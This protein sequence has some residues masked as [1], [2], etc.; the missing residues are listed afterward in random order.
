M[1]ESKLLL[2]YLCTLISDKLNQNL[3]S[4]DWSK[5][6]GR[7]TCKKNYISHALK[8]KI[9]DA[10]KIKNQITYTLHS[11]NKFQKRQNSTLNDATSILRKLLIQPYI[12]SSKY[13]YSLSDGLKS[14]N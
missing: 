3:D 7:Y 5:L 2:I 4:L 6:G 14:C 1:E 13:S 12:H 8:V 10:E 9:I 11:S